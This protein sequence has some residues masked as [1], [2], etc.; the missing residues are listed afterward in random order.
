M[1]RHDSSYTRLAWISP[2]TK[3]W[4]PA[5]RRFA[6]RLPWF[7]LLSHVG[8][9]SW[10]RTT[11]LNV[12]RRGEGYLFALTYG[13]DVDWV[14]TMRRACTMGTRGRT[15]GSSIRSWS[16]TRRGTSSPA[17]PGFMSLL[18]VTDYLVTQLDVRDT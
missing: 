16:M 12:F 10:R 9:R 7:G 15:V 17:G 1:Y 14:R 3:R 5:T 6:D 4:S 18:G 8:R 13:P 2:F 11:P